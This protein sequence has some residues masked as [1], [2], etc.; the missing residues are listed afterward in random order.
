M[1][2]ITLVCFSIARVCFASNGDWFVHTETS[3]CTRSTLGQLWPQ[4]ESP[5]KFWI[6]SGSSLQSN[7]V[8]KKPLQWLA[9]ART[10]SENES[11]LDRRCMR[12]TGWTNPP[13]IKKQRNAKLEL[14]SE[15]DANA[16]Q[17]KLTF[18]LK[19]S[20]ILLSVRWAQNPGSKCFLQ[21][22]FSHP[23]VNFDAKHLC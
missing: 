7:C 4:G 17:I 23:H 19:S 20:P 13:S 8:V 11:H 14:I 22:D 1:L 6:F 10:Q 21:Q 18:W 3:V 12:G 9:R 5:Y 15:C 16:K 2:G